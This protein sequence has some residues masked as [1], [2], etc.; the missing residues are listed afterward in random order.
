MRAAPYPDDAGAWR[1]S[2][3]FVACRKGHD[4]HGYV[5]ALM[6]APSH[7]PRRLRAAF[8]PALVGLV[9]LALGTGS[10]VA[11]ARAGRSH[12]WRHGIVR[13]FDETGMPRTVATAVARWNASGADVH[14][15]R[16]GSASA[17][18][19]V[20]RV[21]DRRLLRICGND[22]LGFTS[23]IGRPPG[24]RRTEVLL[25]ASL[26]DTPRPLSVWVAAHELGH[27]L[28]LQ[29]RA[30]PECSL[31]SAHAF[32]TR[33]PPSLGATSA[34]PAELA[35]VP[36]PADV[37]AAARLYGGAPGRESAACR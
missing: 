12:T 29:H 31:M 5:N 13:Y 35:C 4:R 7:Q 20:L 1:P 26:S 3:L 10:L 34:T 33:C 37:R 15:R 18:Q 14:L 8:R 24:G 21:D 27:V 22:C 2:A 9:L 36:A 11:V 19:L 28:G 30:G 16:V 23:D 17:A 6:P 25:S 32:D